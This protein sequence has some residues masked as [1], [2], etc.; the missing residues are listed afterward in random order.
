MKMSLAPRTSAHPSASDRKMVFLAG[1]YVDGISLLEMA[2]SFGTGTSLVRDEPPK[3]ERSTSSSIWRSTPSAR[4][5]ARAA[6]TSRACRWPYR[7]VSAKRRKPSPRAIAAAVYESSPPLSRTTALDSTRIRIP[8][9]LVQLELDAHRQAVGE[10][11]LGQ[12]ARIH[13]AMNR[14]QM[15][16]R[17]TQRQVVPRDRLARVLVVRA[18]PYDK[19][20]LVVRPK[21][22]E[23]API[24]LAGFAAARTFHIE[25]G[26]DA[27]G[28]SSRAAVAAGLEQHGAT[29]IEQSL[30][31][32]IHII[33]QQWLTAGHLDKGAGERVNLRKNLLK[34]PPGSFMEGIRRV[35]P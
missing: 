30:H 8:D 20:H 9:V 35:A 14:R 26:D 33:L 15:D 29:A 7:T 6:S 1:T 11:P 25:D 34:R 5:T 4:A 22:I 2:R 32:W 28:H 3:A 21:S 19:L 18:I 10:H 16:R 13:D 12:R 17:R 24:V 23:V 31:E 27:F